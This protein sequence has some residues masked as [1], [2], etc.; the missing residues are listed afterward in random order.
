MLV[1]A[2][3]LIDRQKIEFLEFV[4]K[5]PTPGGKKISDEDWRAYFD[6]HTIHHAPGLHQLTPAKY[7]TA[8]RT[9][10]SRGDGAFWIYGVCDTPQQAAEYSKNEVAAR[11]VDGG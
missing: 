8:L 2:T 9:V 1:D 4:S 7:S 11:F 10:K 6:A 5:N 3:R